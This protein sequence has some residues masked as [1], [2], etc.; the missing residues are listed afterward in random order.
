MC[1]FQHQFL[2]TDE[3]YPE[4]G[5]PAAQSV[6]SAYATVIWNTQRII[7]FEIH[8]RIKRVI[9]HVQCNTRL[10]TFIQLSNWAF[11]LVYTMLAV[12]L[13]LHPSQ[14]QYDSTRVPWVLVRISFCLDTSIMTLKS[15]RDF[16]QDLCIYRAFP[17]LQGIF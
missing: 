13:Y 3:C 7:N 12:K 10:C 1:M 8:I 4:A 15:L 17:R 5:L 2:K 9:L 11:S 6:P 14:F 16:S